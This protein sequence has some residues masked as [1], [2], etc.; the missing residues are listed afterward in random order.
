MKANGG[1]MEKYIENDILYICLEGRIS[2]DNVDALEMEIRNLIG[3]RTEYAFDAEKLEYI[4]SAGLRLLLKLKKDNDIMVVNVS[5]A[6]YEIFEITGFSKIIKIK[7]Q[8]RQLAIEGYEKIGEG[9]MGAVYRIDSDTIV[10]VYNLDDLGN[11]EIEVAKAKDAFLLGIPTAIPF[12]IVKVGDKYGAVF[13]LIKSTNCNEYFLRHLNQAEEFYKKYAE[14]IKSIHS[15]E[16]KDNI[17]PKI[18]D[19]Y[20]EQLKAV[21]N[22]LSDEVYYKLFEDVNKISDMYS[23]IHGDIQLKN[24]MISDEEIVLIDMETLSVGNPIFEFAGLYMTYILFNKHEPNN[25]EKFLGI[26]K[27]TSSQLFY[28]TVRNYY[29]YLP[30]EEYNSVLKQIEMLGNIRFLFLIYSVGIGIPELRETRIRDSV[31]TLEKY[32]K[33]ETN[34]F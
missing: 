34:G 14:F 27:D 7:R 19:M 9:A 8:M 3:D 20:L 16:T 32:V 18:K 15:V 10:K 11:I 12:D 24:L 4:S 13:E 1:V 28:S 23:V 26:N 31:E 30:Y 6:I 5:S 33:G 21:K 17:F 29:N 25:T 2:S 22:V